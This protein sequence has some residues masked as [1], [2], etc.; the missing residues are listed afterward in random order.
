VVE[1]GKDSYQR[2]GRVYRGE[3]TNV[4]Q[5]RRGMAWVYRQYAEDTTLIRLRPRRGGA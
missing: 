4:E 3:W 5:V 2:T 1:R